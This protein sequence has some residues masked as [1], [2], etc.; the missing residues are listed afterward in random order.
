MKRKMAGINKV[1]LIEYV[2]LIVMSNNGSTHTHTHVKYNELT[3]E[4]TSY[5][6]YH[7]ILLS[8]L[9]DSGYY[10]SILQDLIN[11]IES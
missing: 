7:D 6:T 11:T 3:S 9:A 4:I 2:K 1:I 10:R 8:N 5:R